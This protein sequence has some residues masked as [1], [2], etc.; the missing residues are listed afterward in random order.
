MSFLSR[1]VPCHCN[2]V[3][4]GI[5]LGFLRH[6]DRAMWFMGYA[7]PSVL[8]ILVIHSGGMFSFLH[9][10][11]LNLMQNP[12]KFSALNLMQ[13]PLKFSAECTP[14]LST[15]LGLISLCCH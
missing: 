1:Y 5:V 15:I 13:S 7:L 9:F 2:V 4:V 12:L 11:Y 8:A 14:I 3:V 6:G 10:S